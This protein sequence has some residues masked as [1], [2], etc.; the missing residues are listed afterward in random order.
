MASTRSGCLSARVAS[1]PSWSS[2][3]P[4]FGRGGQTVEL[5]DERQRVAGEG[6][7]IIQ[8]SPQRRRLHLVLLAKLGEPEPQLVGQP[9]DPTSPAIAS[10]DHRRLDEKA[11]PAA[12]RPQLPVSDRGV[13][14]A[15]GRKIRLCGSGWLVDLFGRESRNE[16]RVGGIH[17]SPRGAASGGAPLGAASGT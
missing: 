4:Q 17:R 16:L 15:C 14:A 12:R 10:S 13:V 3:S 2:H 5:I 1:A 11:L 8:R 9:V 6:G 7:E